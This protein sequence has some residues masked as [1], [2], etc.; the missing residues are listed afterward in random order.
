MKT[1]TVEKTHGKAQG[2]VKETYGKL[3]E[4]PET[5]KEL[6][7]LKLNEQQERN[8]M[9]LLEKISI[10]VIAVEDDTFATASKINSLIVKIRPGEVKK[11]KATEKLVEK[12]VD[13]DKVVKLL[14]N[15]KA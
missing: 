6:E 1:L 12:Y 11:I 13:I 8:V 3:L 7:A 4:V 14:K 9:R 2:S 15:G 5:I 10:P